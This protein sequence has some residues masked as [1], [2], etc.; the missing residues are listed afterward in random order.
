MPD[1]PTAPVPSSTSA[2]AIIDEIFRYRTDQSYEVRRS[3]HSRQRRRYQ[4]EYL[5]K[6][7]HEMRLIRHF[8]NLQRGGALPFSWWHAVS[9][10]V[11]FVGGTPVV[12]HYTTAHGLVDGQMIGVFVSPGGNALNGFYTITSGGSG[13]VLL[14]GSSSGLSGPGAVRVYLPMAVGIFSEDTMA[15]PTKL[16]GP[17]SGSQGYFNFNITIEELFA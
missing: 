16:I 14:N 13:T 8:F 15:S 6:T 2:P 9:E 3:K 10:P 12:V 1:F 17:E 5:G 4:I 11:T 7:T